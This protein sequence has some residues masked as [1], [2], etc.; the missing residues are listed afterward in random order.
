MM[1]RVSRVSPCRQARALPPPER[2]CD[3]VFGGE[4]IFPNHLAVRSKVV[5]T[6]ATQIMIFAGSV[7]RGQTIPRDLWVHVMHNMQVVVEKEKGRQPAPLDNDTAP[8]GPF[9][10]LMFKES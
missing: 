9:M 10:R 6:I 1:L 3:R 4:Q 7:E 8:A 5:A 2:V